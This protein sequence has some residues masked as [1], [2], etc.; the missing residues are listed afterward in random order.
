MYVYLRL[1]VHETRYSSYATTNF[2]LHLTTY[3]Q[4]LHQSKNSPF[5]QNH[6][7]DYQVYKSSFLDPTFWTSTIHS[8]MYPRIHY[9]KS[10][11]WYYS[12]KFFMHILKEFVI[13]ALRTT[14]PVSHVLNLTPILLARSYIF[15]ILLISSLSWTQILFFFNIHG[16]EHSNYIVIRKSQ[17]DA[18]V[19]EFIFI[20]WLLY[21]FRVSS[22]IF[23]STKQL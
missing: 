8:T 6:T 3:M 4:L 23:R 10:P 19:T 20:W 22:P 2:P 1:Y 9:K 13:E 12:L 14:C 7:V 16:S 18:H 5:L 17:P 15:F 11:I 21:M